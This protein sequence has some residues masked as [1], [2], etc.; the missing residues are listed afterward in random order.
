LNLL[1]NGFKLLADKLAGS[2]T[3]G[4]AVFQMGGSLSLALIGV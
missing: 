2:I 3:Y 1:T 4:G